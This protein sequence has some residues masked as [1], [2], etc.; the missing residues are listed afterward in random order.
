MRGWVEVVEKSSDGCN[1]RAGIVIGLVRRVIVAK[2][3]VR[4]KGFKMC[5]TF[6]GKNCSKC[7]AHLA[8]ARICW[9]QRVR[10]FDGFPSILRAHWEPFVLKMCKLHIWSMIV[11]H[12]RVART[13]L[14]IG[15]PCNLLP[16]TVVGLA[17]K[18]TVLKNSV[19]RKAFQMC[20]TFG[21][22]NGSKCVAHLAYAQSCVEEARAHF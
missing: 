5:Y 18:M 3:S 16:G 9:R 7:V 1:W 12:A 22:K 20:C 15:F 19:R 6:G 2:D 8:Y 10:L 17:R 11:R 21:G 13:G 14:K 4:R